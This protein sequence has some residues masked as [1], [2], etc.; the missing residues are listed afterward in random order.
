VTRTVLAVDTTHEYGSIALM[1]DGELLE[2]VAMHA[3]TGFGQVFY[4]ALDALLKRHAVAPAE[5]DCFAAASGPGSF[6]GVRVG[7]ACVKG[8]A[9]ATG[10]GALAVSNLEAIAR[11]GRAP[12][13]AVM[14]DAR[15]GDI[16]AAVYDDQGRIVMPEL[17]MKLPQFLET[18]PKTEV[19]FV[20]QDFSIF[21]DGLP[22]A[23]RIVA[24]RELAAMVARI[25]SVRE[26]R[27]PAQLDANYVRRADAE[28]YWKEEQ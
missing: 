10:K 27:D 20:S 11:Y 4:A 23:P 14:L 6:T 25:A 26:P 16:Y 3:T 24:P 7:V 12:L 22:A 13:R 5:I 18:L 19:D 1:R 9:E 21:G 15:R 2:E 28:L 17:V 8:L